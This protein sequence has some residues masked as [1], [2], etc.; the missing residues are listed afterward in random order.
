[1]DT[2]KIKAIAYIL[3]AVVLFIAMGV[4]ESGRIEQLGM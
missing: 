3:L 4:L 1:M 2:R